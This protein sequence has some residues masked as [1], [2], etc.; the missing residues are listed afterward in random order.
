MSF[1]S[2]TMALSDCNLSNLGLLV[3]L[4]LLPSLVV[5][6]TAVLNSRKEVCDT[7]RGRGFVVVALTKSRSLDDKDFWVSFLAMLSLLVSTGGGIVVQFVVFLFGPRRDK[8]GLVDDCSFAMVGWLILLFATLSFWLAVR[9]LPITSLVELHRRNSAAL[10]GK[11]LFIV[12]LVPLLLAF[13][14][15]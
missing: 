15:P 5:C 7:R 6:A 14:S 13:S 11:G 8:D 2:E 10:L 12:P 1:L 9:L 4:L 3:V